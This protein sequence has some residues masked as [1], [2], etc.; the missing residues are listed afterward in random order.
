[1]SYTLNRTG[2]QIDAIFEKV[3][4]LFFAKYGTTLYS[5]ITTAI[6]GNK[7]V[8]AVKNSEVFVYV[9]QDANN[10]YVFGQPGVSASASTQH[11]VTCASNGTWSEATAA[12]VNDADL[13]AAISGEVASRNQAISD[14][15]AG[16]VYQDADGYLFVND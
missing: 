7:T 15:I 10:G 6:T 13:T 3:D 2:A 11:I 12:L 16:M 14:A 5:E 8:F 1:M 4:G 9:G